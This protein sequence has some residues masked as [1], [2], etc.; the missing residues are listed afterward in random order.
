MPLPHCA[1]AHQDALRPFGHARL[2]VMWNGAG[3][4]QRRGRIAVFVAEIGTDQL[5]LF[6]AK[7]AVVDPVGLRNLAIAGQEHAPRLPVTRLEIAQDKAQLLAR[8]DR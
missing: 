1:K 3:V 8:L 2:V 6:V 5:P 4:H 7:R